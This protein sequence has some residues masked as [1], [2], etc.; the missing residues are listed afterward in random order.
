MVHFILSFRG[1]RFVVGEF[2]F[3]EVKEGPSLEIPA[4]DAAPLEVTPGSLAREAVSPQLRNPGQIYVVHQF[5]YVFIIALCS[6]MKAALPP[7]PPPSPPLPPYNMLLQGG[8]FERTK[9]TMY[10]GGG[11]HWANNVWKGGGGLKG[12]EE[13]CNCQKR[14][15]VPW[16]LTRIVDST[17]KYPLNNVVI[18]SALETGIN[19]GFWG[20]AYPSLG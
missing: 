18:S 6:M 4:K 15:S 11:A 7:P 1:V 17:E 16:L 3:V 20:C 8:Q 9:P 2:G 14:P 19:P 13:L 5:C 10:G 12:E